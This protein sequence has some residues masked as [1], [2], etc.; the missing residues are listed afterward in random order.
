MADCSCSSDCGPDCADAPAPVTVSTS[1]T[2][3]DRWGGVKAR[4]GVGRM[5][6]TVAPGL[7]AVGEPTE[8]SPVLVTANYKLSFDVLRSRIPGRD[9]WILVLDTN[10]INVWCAAGKGTFGTDEIVRRVAAVQL[11][12]VVTHGTLILPQL[13]APGVSA[14]EVKKVSGFRVVYGP[15]R[16]DDLPAFLDAGMKV[17]TEMR[18]VRFTLRD[19]AVLIPVEVS[20]ILGKLI[21]IALALM[22]LSGLGGDGYALGRVWTNGLR[23]TGLFA[24]VVALGVIAFPLLLPWLPGRAFSIKGAWLGVAAALIYAVCSASALDGPAGWAWLVATPALV[25]FL[26]MGFTGS[27]TYT[28]LSGVQREMR[29]ALPLQIGGTSVAAVLWLVGLFV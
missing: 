21:L 12:T 6:Y 24:G 23:Q 3:G 27:S 7:Y 16:A 17:S 14:H 10:G 5:K 26:G 22:A 19:R 11:D 13:G 28:S 1:L 29:R 2:A 15:V 18:R 25:S 20:F 8:E 4:C 9:A